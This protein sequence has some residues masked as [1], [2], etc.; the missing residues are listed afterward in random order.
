VLGVQPLRIFLDKLLDLVD[1]HMLQKIILGLLVPVK[2]L[3]LLL[4]DMELSGI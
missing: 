4:L 1:I 3:V 2:P